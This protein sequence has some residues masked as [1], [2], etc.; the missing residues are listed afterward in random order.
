MGQ[1]KANGWDGRQGQLYLK[2]SCATKFFKL[3]SIGNKETINFFAKH[4]LAEYLYLIAMVFWISF[5]GAR[6]LRHSVQ[7]TTFVQV[8]TILGLTPH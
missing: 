2:F 3:A 4:P 5:I 8:M 6:R 7:R 1:G